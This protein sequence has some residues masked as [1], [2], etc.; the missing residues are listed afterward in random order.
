[1]TTILLITCLPHSEAMKRALAHAKRLLDAGAPVRV[2]FYADGA[3]I[4]NALCWQNADI[5]NPANEWAKLA[6]DYRLNLPVCVSAA[7]ARGI[8]DDDNSKRHHLSTSN[9]KTP[10]VLVGLSE[11]AMM[12][13][14]GTVVQYT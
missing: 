9:L 8:S 7:L 10:F 13:Q 14:G 4:A 1:M 5:T 3:Y 12:L 6:T 2:F 11:F